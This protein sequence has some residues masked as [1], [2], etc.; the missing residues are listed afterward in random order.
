[1]WC[2]QRQF[3]D[4]FL[5]TGL[6]VLDFKVTAWKKMCLPGTPI[7]ARTTEVGCHRFEVHVQESSVL[8][9]SGDSSLCFLC[10]TNRSTALELPP[11]PLH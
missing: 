6:N 2:A 10:R 4:S 8:D 1:V 7:D 9:V 11:F 3:R 5:E